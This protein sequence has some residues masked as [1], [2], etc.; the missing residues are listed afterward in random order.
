MWRMSRHVTRWSGRPAWWP[1]PVAGL[2]LLLASVVV[3]GLAARGAA[4]AGREPGEAERIAEIL[5]LAPGAA[6][7]DVGAGDGELTVALARKVGPQGEL[8]STEISPDRLRAIRRAVDRAGLAQVTVIE[9]AA[10]DSRLPEACCDAILMR[11]VYHHLTA[12][13][14]TNASLF[15]ALRP[16]G[17][18]AVIDF[19]PW[20]GSA[21]PAG[22]RADRGGH[23]VPRRL[24]IGELQAAGFQVVRTE[25]RW[26]GRDYLVLA[27]RQ[28]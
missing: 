21:P 3:L 19:E 15:R 1:A 4:E 26:S 22:V 23:G 12:P 17:L 14:P 20:E 27:R 6:V 9:A 13:E 2:L 10:D 8:Y 16:G 18:L 24:M 25:E 5:Q 28:E 7:A 11:R